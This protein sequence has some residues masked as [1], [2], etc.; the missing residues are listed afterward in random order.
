MLS[1]IKDKKFE[2]GKKKKFISY[3]GTPIRLPK[4]FSAE[5]L[6]ARRVWEAIFKVLKGEKKTDK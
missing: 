4:Y 1:K 2:S 6:K 5:T 3:K